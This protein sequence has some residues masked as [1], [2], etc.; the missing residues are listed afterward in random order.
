MLETHGLQQEGQGIANRIVV[1]DEV[2]QRTILLRRVL[3][4]VEVVT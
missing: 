4:V 3:L 1:V 2:D